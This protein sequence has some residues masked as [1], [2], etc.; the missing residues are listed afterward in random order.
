MIYISP[1]GNSNQTTKVRVL[2]ENP[3][4]LLQASG[5]SP[6]E[7]EQRITY[8]V[9][10][11]ITGLPYVENTR[12][13]SRYALSQVTVVFEKGT[14]IYFARNLMNER[15]QQAKSEMPEGIE[16]VMGPVATG[17]G[18]I[19][20]YAVL[21]KKG[22][23]QANGEAYDAT[24]LRT[25]Q[26]WVI[27]PQLRLVPGV[28]EI[29][30]IGGFEK[31]FHITPNPAQLLA[32]QLIFD[33]LVD[34]IQKNNANVGAD[35]IEKNGEQYLIRAPGQVTDIS[36]IEKI[37]V[38]NRDGIPVTISQVA[39]VGFGKQLRTGAATL[40]GEETVLGTV[41][42]LLGGNSRTVSE[43]VSAKL[44]EI[45][46]TLPKGVIAE[47]VYNRTV[48]VDKPLRLYR[49]ICS[50]ELPLYVKQDVLAP[51]FRVGC[52]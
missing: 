18:E 2:L 17:L 46:K 32:F 20:H 30:T 11:A 47:A 25:L 29:N 19:F 9:E 21:A 1:F 34:A 36:D 40:D 48:L 4:H 8:L 35:Y 28:T 51:I 24:A 37:I 26:D 5:Y 45:N 13:L 27:R 39:E 43:A 38:A 7:V 16:P 22:A 44:V 3:E 31:Q 10:L 15:L 50:K 52:T 33:N 23:K 6:L 12:S 14:D 41:V 42:M 49:L